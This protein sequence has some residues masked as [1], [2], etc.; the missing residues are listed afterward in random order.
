MQEA[1][2]TVNS[3]TLGTD[4]QTACDSL[5]W[6]DGVTYTSSNNTAT[7]TLTNSLGCDSVVSLDLTIN[8]FNLDFTES[9][10]LFTSPPFVVQFTNN[11]PNL[12][13]Y[14][15]TWD[16]GDSTIEQNNNA[17][18]FYEYMY[19][20]LYDVTLI[21]EDITYG[22]GFDTLKKEDLIYCAGGPNLSILKISNN[23]N[24][25]PNPT[26]EKITISVS[27][28]NGN[29]KTEVYDLIGHRL[30]TTNETTISLQDYARGIYLL[31]VAYGDREE[32]V[33]VIKQ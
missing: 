27:N 7:H 33:K 2:V 9:S 30:Q 26:N 31:K 8:E 5:T 12:S 17:S 23:I 10:T 4:V 21:A 32:E 15:F 13:N 14:N 18:L 19:N 20:G 28:Y 3:L 11:T 16:F 29:I 25:F 1:V 6:I 22:C 24:I